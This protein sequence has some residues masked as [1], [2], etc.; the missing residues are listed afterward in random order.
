[1]SITARKDRK[2]T[3]LPY[4]ESWKDDFERIAKQLA[5]I[6]GEVAVS[7]EHVGSTAVTGM[8]GKPTIDILVIITSVQTVD[9]LNDSMIELGY[10]ALGDYVAEN[11]RLFALEDDGERLVNVHCF[12]NDHPHVRQL[13]VMRDFL[14]THPDESK[15]Y[16]Q[17]KLDLYEKHPDDYVAYRAVKDP[18]LKDMQKRAFEWD[19]TRQ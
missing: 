11:G 12:E 13:I 2:Y 15:N 1:M 6:F 3:V 9:T 10:V 18:Y 8:S 4:Q 16:A 5:L 17:L 19:D 14:C 7:I